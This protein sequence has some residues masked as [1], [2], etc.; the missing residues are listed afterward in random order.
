MAS[1]LQGYRRCIVPLRLCF[2]FAAALSFPQFDVLQPTLKIETMRFGSRYPH[3]A[4]RCRHT[5][6]SETPRL[7]ATHRLAMDSDIGAGG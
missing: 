7:E 1:Y 3:Q 4:I 6:L 5:R 2:L